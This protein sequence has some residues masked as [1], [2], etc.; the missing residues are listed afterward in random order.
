MASC[1]LRSTIDF[2]WAAA[3]MVVLLAMSTAFR[4]EARSAH[5]TSHVVREPLVAVQQAGAPSLVVADS[6]SPTT[7][8]L[9]AEEYDDDEGVVVAGGVADADH[10][11]GEA[12]SS[13]ED[14]SSSSSPTTTDSAEEPSPAPT[15]PSL[16]NAYPPVRVSTPKSEPEPPVATSPS[17]THSTTTTTVTTPT[18][19]TTTRRPTATTPPTTTTTTRR[20]TTAAAVVPHAAAAPSETQATP[21]NVLG[22]YRV[23]VGRLS[24]PTPR[25][26]PPVPVHRAAQQDSWRCRDRRHVQEHPKPAGAQRCPQGIPTLP[27]QLLCARQLQAASLPNGLFHNVDIE[28][29]E[30]LNS[31]VQFEKN[32][33]SCSKDCL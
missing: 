22:T 33:F 14:R 10:D 27:D 8:E 26:Y 31:T 28:W 1:G 16:S 18:T 2:R 20:A 12:A 24:V 17:T 29:M 15:R 19:T 21:D 7:T 23:P 3:A 25:G 30:I 6:L 13:T 9:T 11:Q 5:V 4:V 32:F